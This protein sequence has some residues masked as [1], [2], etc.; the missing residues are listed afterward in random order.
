MFL[1]RRATTW[2]IKLALSARLLA[3]W[4]TMRAVNQ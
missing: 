4:M 2:L 3:W 1:L